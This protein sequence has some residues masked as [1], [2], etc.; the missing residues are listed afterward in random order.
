MATKAECAS[1][2][3][4]AAVTEDAKKKNE[5]M[6]TSDL[7]E[8]YNVPERFQYPN[9]MRGYEGKKQHPMYMTT[10]S[11]YGANQPTVHEMPNKWYGTSQQFTG[12]LGKAGMYRNHSLN[13]TM[14]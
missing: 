9:R 13:T 10:S 8:T 11:Q 14:H 5:E 4:F 12:H 2:E 7:Y 1:Q 3:V 6:K